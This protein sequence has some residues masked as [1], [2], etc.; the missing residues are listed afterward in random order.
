[1]MTPRSPSTKRLNPL[2]SSP[3]RPSPPSLWAMVGKKS[4]K[5]DSA[6]WDA[7]EEGGEEERFELCAERSMLWEVGEDGW[8]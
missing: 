6:L 4:W 7:I 1:M 3:I 2:H 8:C 5:L